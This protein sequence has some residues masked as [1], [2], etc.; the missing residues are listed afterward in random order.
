MPSVNGEGDASHQDPPAL[1]VT[2]PRAPNAQHTIKTLPTPAP[3]RKNAR[4]R[5]LHVSVTSR[6]VSLLDS[7][8]SG[9]VA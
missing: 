7:G 4:A 5:L 2:R 1:C 9:V 3:M 6:I 8:G